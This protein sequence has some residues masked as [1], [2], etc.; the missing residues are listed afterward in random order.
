MRVRLV[1]KFVFFLHTP[2][3]DKMW[4]ICARMNVK[5]IYLIEYAVNWRHVFFHLL[6]VVLSFGVVKNQCMN[7]VCTL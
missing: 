4:N 7:K 1:S 2:S 3:Y 5:G 6:V